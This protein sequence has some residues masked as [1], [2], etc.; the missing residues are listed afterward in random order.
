MDTNR[1]KALLAYLFLIAICSWFFSFQ[2]HAASR[3]ITIKA[4]TSSGTT[5]EIRLY[6][7]YHALVVGCGDY[8]A[9]C[10]RK[11]KS[12]HAGFYFMKFMA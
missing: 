11:Q 4:K 3:G 8:Q 2:S 7:G 6:S 9:G 5:K 12:F 10:L 1:I